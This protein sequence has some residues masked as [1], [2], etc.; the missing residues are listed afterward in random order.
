[1]LTICSM[2]IWIEQKERVNQNGAEIELVTQT[3]VKITKKI[4]QNH[5]K[6]Y[7]YVDFEWVIITTVKKKILRG[8]V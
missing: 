6:L 4:V 2:P 5:L 7:L 1:M 8:G 3:C